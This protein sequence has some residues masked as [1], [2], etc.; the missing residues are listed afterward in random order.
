[1]LGLKPTNPISNIRTIWRDWRWRLGRPVGDFG[2]QPCHQG[3]EVS[4]RA[5]KIVKPPL[6]IKQKFKR[7]F[8]NEGLEGDVDPVRLCP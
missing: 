6:T 2:H 3:E 8:I 7:L 4:E 5:T 1:L